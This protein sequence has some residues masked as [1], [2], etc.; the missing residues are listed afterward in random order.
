MTSYLGVLGALGRVNC[1]SEIAG[2]GTT[3]EGTWHHS[4]GGQVGGRLSPHRTPRSWQVRV[5]ITHGESVHAFHLAAAGAFGVPCLWLPA[6]AVGGNLL[7]PEQVAG[8]RGYNT[9]MWSNGIIDRSPVLLPDGSALGGTVLRANTSLNRVLLDSSGEW[10]KVPVVAGQPFHF[11][12][13]LNATGSA[14]RVF[15]RNLAGGSLA[16][17]GASSFAGTNGV[18][19]RTTYSATA[20]AGAAYAICQVNG[21]GRV[22]NPVVSLSTTPPTRSLD[23]RGAEGVHVQSVSAT[24]VTVWDQGGPLG[25]VRSAYD[26]SVVEVGHQ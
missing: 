9:P 14:V 8:L 11:S 13:I 4:P 21:G 24:P 23:G 10:A 1:G 6:D 22:A 25:G 12:A 17:G 2:H 3:R 19:E 5:P 26:V 18:F 20:P 7:T 16:G 15:F